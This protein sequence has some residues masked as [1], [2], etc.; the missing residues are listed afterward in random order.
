MINDNWIG[1]IDKLKFCEINNNISW[2]RLCKICYRC[3]VAGYA[4]CL[5]SYTG[6]WGEDICELA[7][8]ENAKDFGA[9]IGSIQLRN[10][11]SYYP[12]LLSLFQSAARQFLTD[13]TE[14]RNEIEKELITLNK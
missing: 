4:V 13:N 9:G 7:L 12:I 8:F 6:Y 1:L 2:E 14:L 11:D 3:N 5:C 10:N